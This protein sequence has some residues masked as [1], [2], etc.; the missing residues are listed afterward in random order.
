MKI[1]R[2]SLKIMLL[3]ALLVLFSL[4][5][6]LEPYYTWAQRQNNNN[7]CQV[8]VDPDELLFS[9]SNMNPGDSVEESV[10]VTKIGSLPA[11]LFLNW[12][13]VSGSPKPGHLGS[14]FERLH[15]VVSIGNEVLF[16][17]QMSEWGFFGDSP[18][19]NDVVDI[20]EFLDDGLMHEGERIRLDFKIT[21]P[22]PETGNDY[23]GST[24]TTRLIFYTICGD[25]PPDD[26]FEI[27]GFKYLDGT[28][29]GLAGWRINLERQD[30][31]GAPWAVHGNTTTVQDGSYGFSGLPAGRYRVTEVLQPGWNQVYPAGGEHIVILPGAAYDPAARYNFRNQP[32]PPPPPP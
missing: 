19:I 9:L 23:Q 26:T 28:T 14:L 1:Q 21:L 3:G 10:T 30:H 11:R 15:M 16:A 2:Y 18:T 4:V 6:M 13:W 31:A 24:L 7:P 29:Q 27:R 5:L 20:T 12:A 32:P 22:G 17:G 25:I 8:E